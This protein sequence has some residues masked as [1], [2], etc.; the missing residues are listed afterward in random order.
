M[1]TCSA[2]A[3][4][5]FH[6]WQRYSTAT[7]RCRCGPIRP[8]ARWCRSTRGTH[9]SCSIMSDLVA[10]A[11]GGYAP[12]L[13]AYGCFVVFLAA[14]VRGFSGFGFSLLAIT[15][16]SLL[17]PPAAAIPSI[18][19][20]EIAASIHLLPSVWKEVH[21]RSLIWLLVGCV[22]ATPLGVWALASVPPAPMKI[23]LSIF[24][25][26]AGLAFAVGYRLKHM[27]GP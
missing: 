2:S 24:V 8:P 27:P 4:A 14:I 1:P 19:M 16:L 5:V 11:L 12:W 21:W 18:F 10:L 20:L 13:L 23:A 22:I 15:S 25:I 6:S 3:P 17:M 9:R 26:V 7:S